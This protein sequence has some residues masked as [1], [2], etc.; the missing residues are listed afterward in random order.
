MEPMDQAERGNSHT[1]VLMHEAT[2]RGYEIFHYVP[3]TVSLDQTNKVFAHVASVTVDLNK[4]QH[5]TLKQRERADLSGFDVIMFRQDPPYDVAYVTNTVILERL[6][7]QGVLFVNDP[8]WIRNMPDKISI[9]DFA[10]YLPPTLISRNIDEIEA[11]YKKYSDIIIKPLHGFH[12]HGIV[13]SQNINDAK[14]KL[15]EHKEQLMFQPF[16]K[17]VLEGNKRVVFYDGEIVGVLNSVPAS[18][19]EFRIFRNS[20]DVAAELTEREKEICQKVGQILKKRDMLF[21][22]I[23]LIGEYLTEINAGSVGSIFRLD[24][25]Y[26]DNFSAK[27][28]DFIERKITSKNHG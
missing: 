12:G 2:Q 1:L 26:S 18:E 20:K 10:E 13:R 23:D 28:F 14:E 4:E 7:E 17:Q 19:E 9:F 6:K 16:L 15:T 11:F 8:Y 5:Y 22:G 24:E 3:D 27:L 21:V 25:V